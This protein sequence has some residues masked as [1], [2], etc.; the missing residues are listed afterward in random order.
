VRWKQ[1]LNSVVIEFNSIKE[2][3]KILKEELDFVGM[4]VRN[5]VGTIQ[6]KNNV[7]DYSEDDWNLMNQKYATK[8]RNL[9]RYIPVPVVTSNHSSVLE[10]SQHTFE[11]VSGQ[12]PVTLLWSDAVMSGHEKVTYGK[13]QNMSRIPVLKIALYHVIVM[14][15]KLRAPT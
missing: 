6:S 13:Q 8:Q 11:I 4:E 5:S 12:P 10:N 1:E 3:I 9:P 7:S 2:I 15:M 14:P